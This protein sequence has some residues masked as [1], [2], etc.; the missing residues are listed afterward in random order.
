MSAL[1]DRA[2]RR[3]AIAIVVTAA[4][5]IFGTG[6]ARMLRPRS[7]HADPDRGVYPIKGI[8]VSSHNGLVDFRRAAADS[9]S[10][11]FIKASEGTGFSDAAFADNFE[12]ARRAGIAVG[13]Y[14]FF[15]FDSEGW[16]Q[17]ANMLRTIGDRRVDLPLAIDVEEGANAEPGSTDDV[18]EQLHSMVDYLRAWGYRVILY[19]NKSGYRRFLRDR[20]DDHDLWICSFSDPPLPGGGWRLWQHSHRGRVRGIPGPVD[21]NTFCGDSLAWRDFLR[22]GPYL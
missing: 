12:R 14:H 2:A 1:S 8:D 10:F 19:S 16:R 21:L 13:V 17:A 3:A 22:R 5:A 11:V 6:L 20:F 15:R 7:D 9:I 18:V 4:V